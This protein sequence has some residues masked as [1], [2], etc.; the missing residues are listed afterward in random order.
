MDAQRRTRVSR[1]LLGAV[2]VLTTVAYFALG[3]H[4]HLSIWGF[5]QHLATILAWRD[6]DPFTFG[7]LYFIAF[8]V[9]AGLSFPGAVM[10]ALPAGPLFGLVWGTVIVS[11]ASSIGAWLAF[12]SARYVLREPVTRLLGDRL[13]PV[14]D[15]VAR[16]GGFYLFTLRMAPVLPYFIV[17]LLMGLTSMRGAQ[18]YWVSQLGMLAGTV[19]FVHAGNELAKVDRIYDILTPSMLALLALVGA[20][21]W[22]AKRVMNVW[23]ARMSA[24]G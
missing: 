13:Q 11:F 5:K 8:V 10:L 16:E 22:L 4:H 19:L 20:F 12:L 1:M 21:P 14:N 3:L 2:L 7:A 6:A 9:A 17:N 23:R 18:F 24:G 15:G